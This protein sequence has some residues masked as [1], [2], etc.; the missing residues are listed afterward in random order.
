MQP[1]LYDMVWVGLKADLLTKLKPFTKVNGKFNSIDELF[2]RVADSETEPEKY[3]K[4]QQQPPGESSPPGGRKR[5]FRPSISEMKDVPKD[6]FK[7]NKS[8]KS[9]GR[10]ELPP[11]PWV[12]GEIYASR[13]ANGKCLW[14][15]DDHKILQCPKYSKP[16]F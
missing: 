15:G 8:D 16:K 2:D 3:D 7:P 14:C 6:T 4:Q 10:K 11:S 12:T 5:N 9:S 1:M 13:K